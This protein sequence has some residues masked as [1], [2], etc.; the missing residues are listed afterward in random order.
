[1]GNRDWGTGSRPAEV[2]KVT[3]ASKIEHPR[4]FECVRNAPPQQWLKSGDPVSMQAADCNAPV[5]SR[6]GDYLPGT[7]HPAP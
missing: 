4:C 5:V 1:M 6:Q 3:M 7:R 2:V